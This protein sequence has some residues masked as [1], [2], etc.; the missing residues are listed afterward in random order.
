MDP[1]EQL[2]V[3]SFEELMYRNSEDSRKLVKYILG[4]VNAFYSKTAEHRINFDEVNVEHILPQR[5]HKDWNLKRNQ[6]RGYVNMLGNLTLL[7]KRINS[8]I[9]NASLA[10]K[11]PELEKS[12][13]AITK[14]IVKSLRDLSGDWNEAEICK[15]QND[16]GLLAYKKI[17]AI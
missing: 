16:L 9:Q 3:A 14:E 17:W 2:F 4:K 8:K 10:E 12:E 5:P 15:R 7:S 6:I 11:L 1:S 13:L